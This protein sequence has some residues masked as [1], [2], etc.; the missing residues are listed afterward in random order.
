LARRRYLDGRDQFSPRRYGAKV[1]QLM[2]QHLRVTGIEQRIP[3][4]EISA[5]DFMHRVDANADARARTHY[6]NSSLK[7][8]ITAR[9]GSDRARY[10]KFSARL[11]EIVR[12]MSEDFE[13]AAAS[14][15]VLVGDVNAADANKDGGG[16]R[17]DPY[18]E[19]P[20]YRLLQ[21]ALEEAGEVPGPPGVDLYTAARGISVEI[22]ELVQPPQFRTHVGTQARVRK[23][24]RHYLERHMDM[25]WEVTGALAGDLL[26]LAKERHEDFLRYGEQRRRGDD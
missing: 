14:L 3:P 9:I 19:Q 20:V 22:A 17:L 18:T 8:H 1:R 15:A 16:T 13:A 23:V 6:M 12:Q 7:L 4:V 10:Q 24:L 11:D 2:S 26:E 21:H 5:R 25:D